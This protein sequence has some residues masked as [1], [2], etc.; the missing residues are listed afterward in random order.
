[1]RPKR[2]A[3]LPILSHRHRRT[4][5][6]ATRAAALTA[7][8]QL[9]SKHKRLI[10]ILLD[11]ADGVIECDPAT[12]LQ[13]IKTCLNRSGMP[14]RTD[15]GLASEIP[16]KRMAMDFYRDTNGKV[17]HEPETNG[18]ADLGGNGDADE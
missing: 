17:V 15:F 18:P 16:M 10:Q 13:A 9:K 11:M 12:R 6:D 14:E 1:M 5:D 8:N 7:M 4:L 3:E 2:S